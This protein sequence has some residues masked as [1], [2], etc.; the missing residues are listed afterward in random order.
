MK[1]EMLTLEIA[2]TLMAG[3]KALADHHDGSKPTDTAK[4]QHHC[5][6]EDH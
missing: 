4:E 5:Q 1:K 3:A 6:A 2:S